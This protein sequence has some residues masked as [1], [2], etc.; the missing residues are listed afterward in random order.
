MILTM[1]AQDMAGLAMRLEKGIAISTQPDIRWGRRDIKTVQLLASCLAK[2]EAAAQSK[3]DAWLVAPDGTI[4]EGAS[5]NAWIITKAGEI[6][7]R[8]ISN[9]ILAGIT[10][11]ALFDALGQRGLK[12]VER[13]FT[14]EEAKAAAEAFST[15]AT[16]LVTPA[17]IQLRCLVVR[18]WMKVN[19]G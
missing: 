14:L 1:R 10:R 13:S 8:A 5:S 16:A 15:A 11:H 19:T 12:I 4:T 2:T 17:A 7:T 3:D 18:F 9:E 6:V